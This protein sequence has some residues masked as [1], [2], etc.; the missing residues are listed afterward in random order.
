MMTL[1]V[2]T[3]PKIMIDNLSAIGLRHVGYGVK[4]PC[5]SPTPSSSLLALPGVAFAL[6]GPPAGWPAWPVACL[7]PAW[8]LPVCACLAVPA[9]AAACRG[10]LGGSDRFTVAILVP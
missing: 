3:Q 4:V 10:S 7:A 1:D 2:Y 5:V 8:A 6:P 9:C